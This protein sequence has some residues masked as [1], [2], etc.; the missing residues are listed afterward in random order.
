MGEELGEGGG[1]MKPTPPPAI[2]KLLG[3]LIPP[4]SREHVLGDLHERYSGTGQ[5]LYD[6]LRTVPFVILSRIRRTRDPQL[7][8]ME[9]FALYL[10]FVGAAWWLGAVTFLYEEWGLLRLAIP[11]IF[12]LVALM[13]ADAYATPPRRSVLTPM[14]QSAV[15]VAFAFLSPIA[16]TG[17]AFAV[18]WKIMVYGGGASLMLLSGLRMVFTAP[19]IGPRGGA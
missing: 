15:G 1:L 14:L 17:G 5:Y 7:L 4:A 13:L 6:A 11:T 9:A 19:E 12:A 10:S 3:V 18:P 8:L 16:L 2:E